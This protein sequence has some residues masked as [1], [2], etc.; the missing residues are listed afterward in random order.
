LRGGA[1]S[2]RRGG[3]GWHAA[4]DATPRGGPH[5]RAAPTPPQA[6][7]ADKKHPGRPACIWLLGHTFFTLPRD[8]AASLALGLR[9]LALLGEE[10]G[11]KP[12]TV[13]AASHEMLGP[14]SFATFCLG[15]RSRE[16]AAAALPTMVRLFHRERPAAAAGLL[17]LLLLACCC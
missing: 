5:R 7:W 8:T 3:P 11:R 15:V 16:L 14:T 4:P 13:F 10:L 12:S 17:L 9:Y 1:G 2:A 6:L